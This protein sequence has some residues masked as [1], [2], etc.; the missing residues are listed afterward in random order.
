M[1]RPDSYT[2]FDF[3]NYVTSWTNEWGCFDTSS[4]LQCHSVST[5]ALSS[6]LAVSYLAGSPVLVF[7]KW[8]NGIC[9]SGEKKEFRLPGKALS[10]L[11]Q[12]K[13]ALAFTK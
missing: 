12:E 13:Q 2:A 6:R 10:V 5:Y 8:V 4:C 9:K 1:F 7:Q 3:L 11:Q